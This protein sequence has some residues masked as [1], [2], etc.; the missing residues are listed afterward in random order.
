MSF[1]SEAEEGLG[2]DFTEVPYYAHVQC[3]LVMGRV[4]RGLNVSS[5]C[6]PANSYTP[7]LSNSDNA[8]S[9]ISG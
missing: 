1:Q 4:A 8:V 7:I 3:R 6:P 2:A 9:K 5:G